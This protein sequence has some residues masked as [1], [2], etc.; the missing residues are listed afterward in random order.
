MEPVLTDLR[1]G[2]WR[3]TTTHMNM[4]ISSPTHMNMAISSWCCSLGP[5]P[6]ELVPKVPQFH[7]S[8][9]VLYYHLARVIGTRL[10]P[11]F[12]SWRIGMG[13]IPTVGAASW[14]HSKHLQSAAQFQ[15]LQGWKK[16]SL[17]LPRRLRS[18]WIKPSLPAELLCLWCTLE[19][20]CTKTQPKT[21]L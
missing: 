10:P 9:Q 12:K 2:N 7:L 14:K 21:P 1:T 13:I 11:S 5:S 19:R 20:L 3:Y 16:H 17:F 8:W 6:G 18:K 15:W 4:A